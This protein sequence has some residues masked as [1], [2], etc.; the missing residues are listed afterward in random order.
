MI[1]AA[2]LVVT[3]AAVAL[4]ASGTAVASGPMAD[5]G[6]DQ[7]VSVGTTVQL[8]GSGSSHPDGSVTEYEWTIRTPDGREMEPDCRDCQRPQFTPTSVGRYEVTLEVTGP[9]GR[10][11]ED[12]L[13]VYVEEAGPDV[14]LSGD[15]TPDPNQQVT[16][17]A[18]AESPDAQL[19]E[20]A[21]AVE[22]QIVAVRSL[23]GQSDE[24]ELS[25]AFADSET[26]R[27]QV[28]VR[29]SNG[30]TAYDQLYVQ[31]QGG[32][33]SASDWDDVEPPDCSDSGYAARN[34]VE[35]WGLDGS[36]STPEESDD[37]E[38]F[39][40][41]TFEVRYATEGYVELP[42]PSTIPTDSSF[43]ETVGEESGLDGGE[44]AP[45]EQGIVD[46]VVG[47]TVESGS[48]FLFGQEEKTVTCELS[49]DDV[50]LSDC[51]QKISSLEHTGRTTNH[52]SPTE[53]GTYQKYGLR[54]GERVR[55]PDPTA[56]EE[57]QTAE[58]TIVIQ[59]EKDG[60]VDEA[61]K[62]GEAAI[63]RV[64]GSDEGE[65]GTDET[66]PEDTFSGVTEHERSDSPSR[67]HSGF[68]GLQARTTSDTQKPPESEDSSEN[69]SGPMSSPPALSER[70]DR[71]LMA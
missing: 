11:S 42:A 70:N 35:C 5:A 44:N 43:V 52:Y 54:G 57:G 2:F 32:S 34:A 37:T 58:V 24:S 27:V 61:V 45:W 16:Y 63:N 50:I 71:G 39:V 26:Y 60:I 40:P 20:I 48:E 1:R 12:T 14:A 19:E 6:L 53:M 33:V 25:L 15:R 65:S 66:P 4:F 18:V 28:V 23:D 10:R 9:D 62:M 55:G 47:S 36:E 17:R 13:Y 68:E 67:A 30:R 69:T 51:G 56:L 41:E 3:L 46:R 8:D 64:L 22:D 59:Q 29:D 49:G 38:P 21:W 7:T 31:P